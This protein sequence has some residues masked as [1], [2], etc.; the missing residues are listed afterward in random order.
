MA[1]TAKVARNEYYSRGITLYDHAL[2][3]E[4]IAEFERALETIPAEE[5]PERKLTVFYMA[6]SYTTLGLA[7]LRMQMYQRAE[8]ELRFALVVHPEYADLN[9]Y[10]GLVYYRQREYADA[11]SQF[12]KAL[13]IN[14]EY[15]K[16]MMYLGVAR[17]AQRDD[18]GLAQVQ[19]AAQIQ[20]AYGNAR[21]SRAAEAHRGGDTA[22]AIRLLEEVAETDIDEI[23]Y[24]LE[25]GLE[26][27]KREIYPEAGNAFQEA[28]SMC[29]HY[30]DLRN[31]LGLSYLHQGLTDLAVG[32]FRKAL[33]INP[34]FVGA[35][36]SLACAYE[37]NG[38]ADLAI[39]EFEQVLRIDP[40]SPEAKNRLAELRQDA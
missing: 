24:Q 38:K 21:C 39:A 5:T 10:L 3:T 11:A 40:G 33:E 19:Q 23:S 26:L 16:A 32:Q 18:E 15:A 6:E 1:E 4:A 14:P 13:A 17:L 27:L 25:K 12:E 20:P 34:A 28:V 37:Q 2:Y 7:H 36:M 8:E 29:P 35:R 9:F 30:A 31:Y 22:E